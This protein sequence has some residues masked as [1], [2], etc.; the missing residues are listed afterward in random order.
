MAAAQSWHSSAAL[1]PAA[2]A[3]LR[4]LWA[5]SR[6]QA[7]E[8]GVL[9]KTSTSAGQRLLR[10]ADR[11]AAGRGKV[12][13]RVGNGAGQDLRGPQT[14][15]RHPPA[16]GSAAPERPRRRM[17]VS[18]SKRQCAGGVCVPCSPWPSPRA[19]PN[20]PTARAAPPTG[21]STNPGSLRRTGSGPA[22]PH[23]R[24]WP[25]TSKPTG[26]PFRSGPPRPKS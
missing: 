5:V 7:Q 1:D 23:I 26:A 24:H 15:L 3:E 13:A 9:N 17:A 2:A 19:R 14:P 11:A 12:N 4:Q 20:P 16:A 8:L 6:R 25:T 22:I 21:S 10:L 18:A